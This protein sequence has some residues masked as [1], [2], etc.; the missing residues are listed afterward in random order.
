MVLMLWEYQTQ[1]MDPVPNPPLDEYYPEVA[2][3]GISRMIPALRNYFGHFP[4]PALDGGF[5]TK[6]R[7]NRPLVGPTPIEGVFL[8]GAVSGFG[9]MSACGV[10]DLLTSHISGTQLPDYATA[11][12]LDRYDDPSYRKWLE[13]WNESGQL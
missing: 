11:F 13:T 5:Y 9:I 4:R 10:G 1:I 2:L 8:L 6:T 3:R 7:E 12:A